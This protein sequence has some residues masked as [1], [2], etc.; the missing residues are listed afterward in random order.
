MV[1]NYTKNHTGY[2]KYYVTFHYDLYRGLKK[3]SIHRMLLYLMDFRSS[4]FHLMERMVTLSHDVPGQTAYILA[5]SVWKKQMFVESLPKTLFSSQGKGK[6]ICKEIFTHLK[7]KFDVAL[8]LKEIVCATS[9]LD[10]FR[11]CVFKITSDVG[12]D[13]LLLRGRREVDAASYFYYQEADYPKDCQEV[14]NQCTNT[15]DG[16][17]LIKPDGYAEPF[18]VFCNNTI[19]GGGWT[20]FQRRKYGDVN[21]HRNWVDYKNGFG[22]LHRNFWLGNDK[23]AYLTNQKDYELRIDLVSS[24]L[25]SR[26]AHYNLFRISDEGTK[27]KLVGLGNYSG[28]SGYNSFNWNSGDQFS[29]H[30]QDND[31][32]SCTVQP[33]T[34]SGTTIRHLNKLIVL[35]KRGLRHIC[36]ASPRDHTNDLFKSLNLLLKL[37]DLI[38]LSIVLIVYGTNST[39]YSL[40][41]LA[42]KYTRLHAI[43]LVL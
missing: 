41:Y 24:S 29:T 5:K 23:L 37:S 40:R 6:G 34:E 22:F 35:Q 21:F 28:N 18:E 36:S 10:A 32:S 4:L 42:V 27:Y 12:N 25:V 33:T 30:D 31:I 9:S 16:I 15:T 14:Y 11:P 2:S 17:Y 1:N 3:I 26:F 13:H 19:D 39:G 8:V 38:R 20:V 43:L 7:F